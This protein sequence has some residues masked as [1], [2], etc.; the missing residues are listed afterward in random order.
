MEETYSKKKLKDFTD[1]FKGADF[2]AVLNEFNTLGWNSGVK[3][4]NCLDL[5]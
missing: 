3:T 2:K 5:V 1:F 4:I